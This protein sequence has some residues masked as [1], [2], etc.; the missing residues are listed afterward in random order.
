MPTVDFRLFSVL[1]VMGVL[2]SSFGRILAGVGSNG[3]LLALSRI[4]LC[5][6][7]GKVS[8]T[9]GVRVNSVVGDLGSSTRMTFSMAELSAGSSFKNYKRFV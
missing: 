3:S 8:R 9:I 2:S 1:E 4:L 6:L 5:G 7:S